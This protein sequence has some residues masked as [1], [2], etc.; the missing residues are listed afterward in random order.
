MKP[1]YCM[2]PLPNLANKITKHLLKI[3]QNYH[4]R[5]ISRGDLSLWIQADGFKLLEL[6]R[7]AFKYLFS[8][9]IH[10]P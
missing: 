10:H 2:S 6:S 7:Q 5:F 1:V 8:P 4:Q 3:K 9:T